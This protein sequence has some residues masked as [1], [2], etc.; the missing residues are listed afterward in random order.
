MHSMPAPVFPRVQA[1]VSSGRLVQCATEAAGNR[2]GTAGTTLGQA[3]LQWALSAAA[4]LCLRDHAPAPQDLARLAKQQGQGTAL[5]VLAQQLAR[6]VYDMR[7]RQVA[8]EQEPFC[9]R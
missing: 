8:F 7:K 3:P 6:A 4:G 2:L 9:H 1:V 5:S